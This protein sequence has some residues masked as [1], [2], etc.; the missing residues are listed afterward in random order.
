MMDNAD[1]GAAQVQGYSAA[2]ASHTFEEFL[3]GRLSLEGFSQWL[4]AYPYGANGPADPGVEDEINT[5][6]LAVRA[7]QHGTRSWDE[8]HRE[9][10]DARRRL[11]GLAW[12]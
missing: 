11:T 4:R 6:T 2:E 3:E 8:V 1:A 9:L 12:S 7:F 10:M 5:A